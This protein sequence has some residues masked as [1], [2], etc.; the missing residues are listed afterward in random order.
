ML[1]LV[2]VAVSIGMFNTINLMGVLVVLS[3]AEFL[4]TFEQ[5]QLN[6]IASGFLI[7]YQNGYVITATFMGLWLLPLGLLSIQ[8]KLIPKVIGVLLVIG[9]FSYLGIVIVS[10]MLPKFIEIANIVFSPPLALAEFTMIGWL[11]IKGVKE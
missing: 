5:E 2:I 1:V 4:N 3:G 10:I 6:T 7:L 9:F 8:S 11:L